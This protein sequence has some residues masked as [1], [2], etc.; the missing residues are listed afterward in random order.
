MTESD[1]P[2]SLGPPTA[3][4]LARYRRSFYDWVRKGDEALIRWFQRYKGVDISRH[5][6]EDLQVIDRELSPRFREMVK[7]RRTD[8]ERSVNAIGCYLGGV[9]ARNL[10]AR[11]HVPNYLQVLTALFLNVVDPFRTHKYLYV[12][13]GDERIPVLHAAREAIEMTSGR[14]S[15]Y[16]FYGKYAERTQQSTLS[17]SGRSSGRGP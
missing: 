11:W 9:F 13:L 8:E 2:R 1:Q 15:L 10:G 17:C 16:A 12:V 6:P 7:R 14:F 5:R 4:G 3:S